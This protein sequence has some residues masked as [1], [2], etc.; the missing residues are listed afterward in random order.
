MVAGVTESQLVPININPLTEYKPQTKGTPGV[1][2]R[3]LKP[4]ESMQAIRRS[5]LLR[6][7]LNAP[8]GD[9]MDL[10]KRMPGSYGAG[11][12]K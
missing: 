12:K 2:P 5:N 1:G 4:G 7:Y 3:G 8:S 11:K 10:G 6:D 9:I